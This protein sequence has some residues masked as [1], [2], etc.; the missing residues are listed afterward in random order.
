MG[1]A[2]EGVKL[3]K[4]RKSRNEMQSHD[5]HSTHQLPLIFGIAEKV[6]PHRFYMRC[7]R[8]VL[9]LLVIRSNQQ[10]WEQYDVRA[11]AFASTVSW[12]LGVCNK[13]NLS[14][15][16][17]HLSIAVYPT[18]AKQKDFMQRK[19]LLFQKC[20]LHIHLASSHFIFTLSDPKKKKKEIIFSPFGASLKSSGLRSS[21]LSSQQVNAWY[22]SDMHFLQL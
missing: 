8:L 20:Y 9:Y 21:E 6:V 13:L 3:P 17:Y 11:L 12:L 5:P 15:S 19:F 1:L 22:R 7:I 14:S 4:F 16:L 10:L 2:V 18:S